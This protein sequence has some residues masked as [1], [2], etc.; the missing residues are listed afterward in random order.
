MNEAEAIRAANNFLLQDRGI[1][2]TPIEIRLIQ[3]PNA[4]SF[5][6]VSYGTSIRY[7]KETAEGAGIDGGEYI[8]KVDDS[9]GGV[10]ILPWM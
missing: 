1:L 8:L 2:A 9:S 6:W 5:W 10:S 3:R 7:P 4:P